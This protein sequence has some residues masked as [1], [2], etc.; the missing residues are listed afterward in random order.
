MENSIGGIDQRDPEWL[1]KQSEYQG[2]CMIVKEL[3]KKCSGI[4]NEIKFN[5]SFEK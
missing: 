1:K 2:E 4:K 3:K 5:P